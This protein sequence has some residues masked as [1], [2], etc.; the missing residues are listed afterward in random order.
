MEELNKDIENL[1]LLKGMIDTEFGQ[2]KEIFESL[3]R[4]ITILKK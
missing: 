2:G 1:E 4:V 3:E